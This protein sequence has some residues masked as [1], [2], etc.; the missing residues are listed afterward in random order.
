MHCKPAWIAVLMFL[1]SSAVQGQAPWIF[2]RQISNSASNMPQGLPGGGIA[3]GSIFSIY[4]TNLGPVAPAQASSYPLSTT[5]SGVSLQLTQGATVVRALPIYVSATQINAIM[6]SNVPL[7]LNSLQITFNNA[8]S[9]SS[10]VRVA[11]SAVGIFTVLGTGSGPAVVQNF[12]AADNLPVN[13]AV[14]AASPG[15]VVILWATGLGATANDTIAP[16]GVNL[17]TAVE[18]FVG[19]KLASKTYSGRAP[20]CAGTDQIAFAI[21]ADAPQGCWVPIAIRTEN[22]AV[23]NVATIAIGPAGSCS[24][25][26]NPLQ[27]PLIQGGKLGVFLGIRNTVREDAGVLSPVDVQTDYWYQRVSQ[28]P[29]SPFAFQPLLSLPP[30]GACNAF[31]TPGDFFTSDEL[32]VYRPGGRHLDAGTTGTLSGAAGARSLSPNATASLLQFFGGSATGFTIPEQPFLNPGNYTLNL[33]G[34]ADV[35]PAQATLNGPAALTWTNRDQLSVVDRARG[36]PVNWSGADASQT[37]LVMGAA[38]DLPSNASEVFLCV[39][40]PG[41]TSFAVPATALANLPPSRARLAQS[42]AAVYVIGL[43]GSAALNVTA[44]NLDAGLAGSL[45]ISGK[46]VTLR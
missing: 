38:V 31:S 21:P 27:Q 29:P 46:T 34:G 12:A 3:R 33:S 11:A 42:K 20:C 28:E 35:G 18:V 19:G 36:F 7:G 24:D 9:N 15:Q 26:L 1:G 8:K 41:S 43:P 6:P 32:L 14:T 22:A 44:G 4:G 30:A 39:A 17:P 13:S 16:P 37:I 10:P 25:P 5:L 2:P 40:P 23:S 45:S